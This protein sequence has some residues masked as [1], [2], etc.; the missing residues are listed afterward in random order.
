MLFVHTAR[1]KSVLHF[2]LFFYWNNAINK[3]LL[4]CLE[5]ELVREANEELFLVIRNLYAVG[6]SHVCVL[7]KDKSFTAT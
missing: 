7:S 1:V 6:Y 2:L 3:F 5:I 4:L